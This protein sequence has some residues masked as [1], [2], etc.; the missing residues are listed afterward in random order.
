MGRR[1]EFTLLELLVVISVIIILASLLLRK[2]PAVPRLQ[3]L[4]FAL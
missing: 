1:L 3:E 2:R 4:F